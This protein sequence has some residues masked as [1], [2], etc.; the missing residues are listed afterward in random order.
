MGLLS[1]KQVRHARPLLPGMV[2]R[3]D[4]IDGVRQRCYTRGAVQGRGSLMYSSQA[5]E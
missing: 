1:I 2:P 4:S 5:E 3:G